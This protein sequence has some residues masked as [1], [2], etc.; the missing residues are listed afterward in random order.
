MCINAQGMCR[1]L[2]EPKIS[3][4]KKKIN[5]NLLYEFDMTY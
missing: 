3:K 5:K 2:G 4:K 1:R